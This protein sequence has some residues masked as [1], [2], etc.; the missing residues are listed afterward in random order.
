LKQSIESPDVCQQVDARNIRDVQAGKLGDGPVQLDRVCGFFGTPTR[1]GG[2]WELTMK[3][4][5][6]V[7]Y[8]FDCPTHVR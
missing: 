8:C 2:K 1:T 5:L 3:S 6:L 4:W 7:R